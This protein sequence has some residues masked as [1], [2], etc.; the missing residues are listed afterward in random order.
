MT[1][2]FNL[3]NVTLLAA[4]SVNI[5]HTQDALMISSYELNF[6]S[7]KLLSPIRPKNI[8]KSI[9]YIQ[10]P[11]I[12]LKGYNNLILNE[13]DKYFDTSHCLIVQSDAFVS[14]P[15]C[16]TNEFLNYDY[17]GA[18]WTKNIN[19]NDKISLD[20][21]K[22]RVGNGGFSLRSKKLLNITKNLKYKDMQFPVEQEDVIICYYL[23]DELKKKGIKFAPIDLAA[24]FSIE[25][26]ETN[27]KFG[28]ND[29]NSF[30]FHGKHLQKYFKDRFIKKRDLKNEK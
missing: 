12:D 2:K 26:P 18:P 4:S 25:H 7:I 8:F 23:Y 30:G 16:W 21:K 6:S 17:I 20:L 27:E 1:K 29:K 5:E 10:I 9:E 28:I 3:K 15:E 19:P 22:N 11:N 24:K 14:N 13:L